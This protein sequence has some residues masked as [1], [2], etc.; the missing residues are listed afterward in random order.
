[1]TA[2]GPVIVHVR[3]RVH[4][5]TDTTLSTG[6]SASGGV[7]ARDHTTGT[8]IWRG[9]TQAGLLRHHLRAVA[10][11]DTADLLFGTGDRPSPVHTFDALA[12]HPTAVPT[13]G[14]RPG[15]RVD[16]VTGVV[17]RGAV[18]TDEVLEPPAFFDTEWALHLDP[19]D[20]KAADRVAAFVVALTGLADGSITLGRRGGRGRGH[21]HTDHWTAT[22]H[23]LRTPT[24]QRAWYLRART[25]PGTGL[26]DGTDPATAVDT[27]CT[28]AP[29][30]ARIT[31]V[32]AAVWSIAEADRR[33]R[34][35]LVMTVDS[36]DTAPDGTLHPATLL[37]GSPP[38][39]RA[40]DA[41]TTDRPLPVAREPLHRP[42]RAADTP[43][44]VESGA[45]LH[46]WLARHA[47]WILHSIAADAPDPAAA[48]R[49]DA[50]HTALFGSAAGGGSAPRPSRVRVDE[51]ELRNGRM[52]VLPRVR[53]DPL[54]HG[55]VDSALF[56]DRVLVG[57]ESTITVTVTVP[58]T[59]LDLAT[60]LIALML[61][62]LADGHAPPVGGGAGVGHGRRTLTNAKITTAREH[63]DSW[64]RFRNSP[65]RTRSVAALIAHLDRTE[66]T[67]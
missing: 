50:L 2:A 61:R 53:I 51:P 30:P 64:E 5:D 21:V 10:G 55:A 12:H 4:L 6:A 9:T 45:A 7:V 41:D 13:L 54:T 16:P 17:E 44:P 40:D 19:T 15:N 33:T 24:G 18:F 26:A 32:A 48:D 49:A 20:R 59:L 36:A 66:D 43:V 56:A 31:G 11:A 63:H 3:A 1:M 42:R 23:D 47:R 67:P 27:A 60:G 52:A 34:L 8:P 58:D 65:T 39:P 37:H 25:H 38:A 62:D 46:N 35:T 29:E 28:C 14:Y 22:V 57:A